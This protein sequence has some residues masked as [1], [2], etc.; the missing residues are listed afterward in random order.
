MSSVPVVDYDRVRRIYVPP[1]PL[2]GHEINWATK[3]CFFIMFIGM[4]I[5]IKRWRDKQSASSLNVR[6]QKV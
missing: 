1:D 3:I 6:L 2:P 4:L 5:L